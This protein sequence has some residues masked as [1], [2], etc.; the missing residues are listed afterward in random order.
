MHRSARRLLVPIGLT[1][2]AAL[3]AFGVVPAT[4]SPAPAASAA[5]DGRLTADRLHTPTLASLTASQEP[6]DAM[7]ARTSAGAGQVPDGALA[8]AV[9]QADAI[10][11]YTA[12][13]AP[14]IADPQWQL[15]GPTNIGGRVLDV[16][17]DPRPDKPDTIT[18]ALASSG[19]WRSTDGGL[20]YTK[21]W[22]ENITQN[23]GAL[24]IDRTGVLYAGTGESGPGG[25]SLTYGGTGVYKSTDDGQTWTALGLALSERIGR[26]VVDPKDDNKIFVAANGPLYKSGGER[27]L[28]RSLNGGQTFDL[29]LPGINGT[30][31]AVDV[32]IDP[33]D[34]NVV[35]ATTWQRLRE[36]DLRSYTGPGSAV[37]KSTDGGATFAPLNA[38]TFG[39]GLD[40][41]GRIGVAVAPD[42]T[43]YIVSSTELGA[44]LFFYRCPLVAGVNVCGPST[45]IALVTG[46]FV[47]AWWFGRIYVD[48]KNSLH[49]FVMGVNLSESTNGGT[50]FTDRGGLLFN[51]PHADQHGFAFDPKRAN[52]VY[53][54]NDGGM[55]VSNDNGSTYDLKRLGTYQ[56]WNQLYSVD[57][58]EQ[59]PERIVVG[60]QDNGSN[61]SY[62]D[63]PDRVAGNDKWNSYGGG[64]GT[65]TQI[66]P[67]DD[68]IVY[69][70]SQYGACSV[71]RN[72]GDSN[73]R[74]LEIESDR[75]N[76]LSPIQFDP[77][78]PTTVYFAGNRLGRSDND[79]QS[80]TMISPDLSNGAG[81]ENNPLFA[82]YGTITTIAP[83]PKATGI[84]YVGTDDGNVQYTRNGG[85]SWTKAP[86]EPAAGGL[87]KDWVTQVAVDPTNADLAYATFSGFRIGSDRKAV[88][89]TTN[90]GQSWTDISGNLPQSPVNDVVIIGRD[91]VVAND[92]GVFLTKGVASGNGATWLRVG[93]GLPLAPIMDVDFNQ[94]TSSLFAANFG[95]GAFSVQLGSALIDAPDPVVPE[96]P[97]PLL[98][99]LAGALPLALAIRR[100]RRGGALTA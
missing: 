55:Y 31:G 43:L 58:S 93:T 64:D 7:L 42:Q 14:D 95:F 30:T 35:Y 77:I 85:T 16:V 34:S 76:W 37:Y 44:T 19:V 53:L 65:E 73:S 62:G 94:A 69:G 39:P 5:A 57:V 87:P 92:V 79:G 86:Q 72:G 51:G 11:S 82:N 70:C 23:I 8:R 17:V 98:L 50:T 60:L 20:T 15:R 9:A 25:G 59:H 54:G 71:S 81:R 3:A 78:N 52:R 61:R 41:L 32:A 83:A 48:P 38:G 100:G 75:Y 21:A 84:I 89:R 29:V 18:V 68:N 67:T 46:G 27:G 33:V 22:P 4:A 36:P 91:L 28:Y 56:P 2:A 13:A 49:L 96:V 26:V 63:A 97:W 24:A 12:L 10:G 88:Y 40:N 80:F 1:A 90:G 99:P 74:S 47:Y 45:D 66:K 6:G